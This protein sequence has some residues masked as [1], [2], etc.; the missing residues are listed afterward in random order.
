MTSCKSNCFYIAILNLLM[1]FP[2]I[3]VAVNVADQ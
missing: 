2:T 3:N 1:D